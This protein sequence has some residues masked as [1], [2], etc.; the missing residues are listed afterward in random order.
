MAKMV[1]L[2]AHVSI[3]A[4]DLSQY[5]SKIELTAEIEE[6]DVTTFTSGG[7]NESLGGL[8]SG[9]LSLTFKQDY[10]AAAVDDIMWP[11][12]LS[13]TPVPF[14]VRADN[15]VVGTNNPEYSGNVGV[16]QWN[17]VMGEVGN[18]AQAEV[19]FPT[20]GPISRATA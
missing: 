4:N 5:C 3:D 20:S 6:Q 14:A 10:D 7:W 12:F 15:A 11:L 19:E 16:Y 18:V 1:L 8:G 13:R 17:P 2:A 9:S